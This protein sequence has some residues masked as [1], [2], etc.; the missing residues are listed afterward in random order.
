[1][2]KVTVISTQKNDPKVYNSN[3]STWGEL[4]G[5]IQNDFG[6][7]SNMKAVVKEN[8]EALESSGDA[9]PDG[10]FTIFLTQVKIKAGAVDMTEILQELKNGFL[11][12][13][14]DVIQQMNEG[15]FDTD[16][17][18]DNIAASSIGAPRGKISQKD[19][20]S[21]QSLKKKVTSK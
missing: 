18:A 19:M 9:L 13:F 1:M 3:A 20:E 21:L 5:Y 6:D 2:R 14:E 12:T 11:Q 8:R 4:K 16:D 7:L 17:H 10:D 15:N